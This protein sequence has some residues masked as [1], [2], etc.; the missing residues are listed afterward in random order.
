MT[1]LQQWLV[2]HGAL[3]LGVI[4]L[5]VLVLNLPFGFW[6]AGT[7]KFSFAWFVAVHAPV[8]LVVGMR[9]LTGTRFSLRSVLLFAP[10]YL[11]G[12][13]LGGRLR[14]WRERRKGNGGRLDLGHVHD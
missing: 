5:A 7:R 11:A 3:G 1:S 14:V 4:A 13:F 12:Q 9:L 6:R 2:Q 8:P 10:A